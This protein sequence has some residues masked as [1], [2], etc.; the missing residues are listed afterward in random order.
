MML[1]MIY[2]LNWMKMVEESM[3]RNCSTD[4]LD[5][6]EN[7]VFSNG[8]VNNWNSLSVH[9]IDSSTIKYV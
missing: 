8:V 3:T 5:L 9:S 6:T 1:I 7:N 2:G 4:D